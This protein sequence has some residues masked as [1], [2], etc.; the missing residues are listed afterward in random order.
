MK[1]LLCALL[2]VAALG[3]RGDLPADDVGNA[4]Q[5][6]QM[7]L[8]TAKNNYQNGLKAYDAELRRG[9]EREWKLFFERELAALEKNQKLTQD[10]I[11]G[12]Y[13]YLENERAKVWRA[14]DAKLAHWLSD[15]SLD[16]CIALADIQAEFALVG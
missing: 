3:C 5:L 13:E 11:K 16:Q 9:Y 15:D 10:Q 2:L 7:T 8:K 14:L 4:V 6:Q 1:Y 12:L